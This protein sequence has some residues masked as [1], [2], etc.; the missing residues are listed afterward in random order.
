MIDRKAAEALG[1][2]WCTVRDYRRAHGIPSARY[3]ADRKPPDPR[4]L[5]RWLAEQWEPVT[6]ATV[7]G[8]LGIGEDGAAARLREAGALRVGRWPSLWV[9]P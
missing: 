1:L 3:G 4:A 5:R 8:H 2:H 6:T 7:A 9:A